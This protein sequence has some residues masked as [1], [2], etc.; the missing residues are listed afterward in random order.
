MH[1]NNIQLT[2]LINNLIS[3]MNQMTSQTCVCF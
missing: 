1:M 2:S 3:N